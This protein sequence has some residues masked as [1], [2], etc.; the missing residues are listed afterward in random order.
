MSFPRVNINPVAPIITLRLQLVPVVVSRVL[1]SIMHCFFIPILAN[2]MIV[3]QTMPFSDSLSSLADNNLDLTFVADALNLIDTEP[4]GSTTSNAYGYSADSFKPFIESIVP[5]TGIGSGSWG[6]DTPFG[7]ESDLSTLTGS[8]TLDNSFQLAGRLKFDWHNPHWKY[9]WSSDPWVCPL[10]PDQAKKEENRK[11]STSVKFMC[12]PDGFK[13]PCDECKSSIR[14]SS[15]LTSKLKSSCVSVLEFNYSCE[16]GHGDQPISCCHSRPN[17]SVSF[18]DRCRR[19][20]LLTARLTW[21]S[22]AAIR[23]HHESSPYCPPTY[24]IRDRKGSGWLHQQSII[25]YLARFI[26]YLEISSLLQALIINQCSASFLLHKQT[27]Q[28]AQ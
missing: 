28:P 13:Q 17:Q 16:V 6:G 15:S 22:L 12:C 10:T 5:S 4:S 8:S 1:K 23:M 20:V 14:C 2:F 11:D 3:A 9:T 26:L 19:Q 7:F 24:N 27:L 25:Q 21:S 18:L